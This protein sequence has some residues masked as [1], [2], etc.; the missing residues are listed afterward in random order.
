MINTSKCNE[1][2]KEY[3]AIFRFPFFHQRCFCV[4]VR[5]SPSSEFFLQNY[6]FSIEAGSKWEGTEEWHSKSRIMSLRWSG[7]ESLL[8]EKNRWEKEGMIL[9]TETQILKPWKEEKKKGAKWK[10]FQKQQGNFMPY[11]HKKPIHVRY[12]SGK[13]AWEKIRE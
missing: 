10:H 9:Y 11:S 1:E 2:S 5:S 8:L 13:D 7:N 3:F 6:V 4:E 12:V